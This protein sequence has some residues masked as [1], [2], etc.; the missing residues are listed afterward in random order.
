MF[1]KRKKELAKA[2]IDLKNHKWYQGGLDLGDGTVSEAQ[3]DCNDIW[4][5]MGIDKKE[6]KG[7]RVLDIACCTGFF[8]FKAS[9]LK[10][11]SVLGFD[12][13][14]NEIEMANKVKLNRKIKNIE[15]LSCPFEGF[16]WGK[17][18]PFD[19]SFAVRCLYHLKGGNI[20]KTICDNT[21]STL[22]LF[23]ML[24]REDNPSH[25]G[26]VGWEGQTWRYIPTFK[27]LEKDLEANGFKIE[28]TSALFPWQL[29][30]CKIVE[31]ENV[32]GN[33]AQRIIIKAKR[34]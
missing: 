31:S 18:G 5:K 20:L 32:Y 4:V 11:K 14:Q 34:K 23:T 15:F 25:I 28:L 1:G 33:T 10:A 7:K 16:D 27:Q 26:L 21:K 2:S 19:V 8:A 12:I 29:E 3:V 17:Y 22:V 30:S 9:E 13:N 6:I 24:W